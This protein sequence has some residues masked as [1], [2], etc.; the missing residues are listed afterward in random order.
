M[1][2][3]LVVGGVTRSNFRDEHNDT[4]TLEGVAYWSS[5]EW[6]DSHSELH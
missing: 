4:T 1:R 5:A 2:S 3:Q 6:E